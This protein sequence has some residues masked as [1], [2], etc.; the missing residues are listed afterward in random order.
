M[1]LSI[2][3]EEVITNLAHKKDK[4]ETPTSIISPVEIASYSRKYS[5]GVNGSK[6]LLYLFV[7]GNNAI[8]T[9]LNNHFS[10]ASLSI[11][12]VSSSSLALLCILLHKSLITLIEI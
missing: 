3:S 12:K 7:D 9:I 8:K 1:N 4:K 11:N 5:V 6:Y 10:T 2:G